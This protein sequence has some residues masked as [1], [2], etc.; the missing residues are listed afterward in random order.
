MR[1]E[2][3]AATG[4]ASRL[5]TSTSRSGLCVYLSDDVFYQ[6][7]PE[8]LEKP[9]KPFIHDVNATALKRLQTMKLISNDTIYAVVE[10]DGFEPTTSCLQSTRSTN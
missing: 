3:A 2:E 5:W 1:D 4:Q 8:A 9:D 6:V 7:S 10:P